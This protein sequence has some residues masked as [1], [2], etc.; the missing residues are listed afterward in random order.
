[1]RVISVRDNL[2]ERKFTADRPKVFQRTALRLFVRPAFSRLF[3]HGAR[4]VPPI[5]PSP[6]EDSPLILAQRLAA[7]WLF[8]EAKEGICTCELHPAA[9]VC[10]K[11]LG[12]CL[13]ESDRRCVAD[14]ASCFAERSNGTSTPVGGMT[15]NMRKRLGGRAGSRDTGRRPPRRRVSMGRWRPGT[16][17]VRWRWPASSRSESTNVEELLPYL[18][19]GPGESTDKRVREAMAPTRTGRVS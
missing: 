6:L 13:V 15:T 19:K 18:A 17:P 14:R 2:R 4:P 5:R 16:Y 12:L 1:M 10:R 7:V 3:G 8:S 11:L 9:R